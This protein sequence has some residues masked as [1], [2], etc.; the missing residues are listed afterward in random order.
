MIFASLN[1]TD[2]P[3]IVTEQSSTEDWCGTEVNQSGISKT[4]WREDES[5][6]S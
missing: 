1:A 4:N 6:A 2:N 3:S 5:S